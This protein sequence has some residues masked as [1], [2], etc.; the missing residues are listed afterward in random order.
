ME[1]GELPVF[2]L[3]GRNMKGLSGAM[4]KKFDTKGDAEGFIHSHKGCHKGCHKGLVLPDYYGATGMFAKWER[5]G[6]V[7]GSAFI[8][9]MGIRGIFRDGFRE[10]DQ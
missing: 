1:K 2:L 4:F 9:A 8:L 6:L 5:G 7:L 10:T 3:L